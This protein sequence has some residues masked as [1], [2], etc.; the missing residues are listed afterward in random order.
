MASFIGLD[1]GSSAVRAVQVSNGGRGPATLERLGQVLLP[2]GAVRDGEIVEPDAVVD[3]LRTLWSRHGFKGR[4]VSLGVANQQ[5][6]VRQID[7]PYLPDDEL[8]Q[9]LQLQ[10]QE[11]IPIP[12]EQAI[13]DF[14][15]LEHFEAEDGQRMSRL[16]LVAAQRQMVEAFVDVVRRA[17]LKPISVDLDAFAILRSLAPVGVLDGAEAELLVEVGAGV[18]N[19]VVHAAG[20]PRFVRILVMGGNAITESLMGSDGLTYE[21]AEDVKTRARGADGTALVGNGRVQ[22]MT[23]CADRFVDEIRGSVD[24]YGAQDDAVAIRRVVLTGGASQLPDLAERL[25]QTLQLPVDGG[26][27]LQELR[28]GKLGLSGEQLVEAQPYLA[29]ATGLALGELL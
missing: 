16:L 21:E 11:V 27:P 17:K 5:V 28:I 1:I 2:V 7:V 26:H 6:V 15:T 9:S 24:Y 13:L 10:V 29:V 8:R 18:T 20:V 4:K 22:V 19:L 23:R 12:L 25:G 3:A 14:H